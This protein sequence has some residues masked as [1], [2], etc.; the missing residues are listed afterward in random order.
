MKRTRTRKVSGFSLPELVTVILLIGISAAIVMPRYSAALCNY[1][2]SAAARRLVAD[3]AYAQS[4]A[5]SSSSTCT[6]TFNPNA[7]SYQLS[8]TAVYGASNATSSVSLQADPFQATFAS[9][10]LANASPTLT[11][12]GYGIPSTGGTIVIQS[13]TA[14][15]TL[16]IDPDTGA[17]I[18]Q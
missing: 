14:Q 13:G 2:V 4:V 18:I 17:A 12:N 5:K 11:F 10:S 15:K 7:N 3:L 1:R 6:I 8:G 9:I 16:T